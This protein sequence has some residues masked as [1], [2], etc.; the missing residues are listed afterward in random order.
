MYHDSKEESLLEMKKRDVSQ[1]QRGTSLS[2]QILVSDTYI[3]LQAP[4]SSYKGRGWAACMVSEGS[5]SVSKARQPPNPGFTRSMVSRV[6]FLRYFCASKLW[7][8][9]S[10]Y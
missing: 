7:C 10:E 8:S 3:D 1:T 5:T 6:A 2:I 4:L 9:F